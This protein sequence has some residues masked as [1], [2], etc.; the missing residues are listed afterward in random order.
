MEPDA[1][2]AEAFGAVARRLRHVTR[3]ALT[4]LGVT[5]WQARALWVLAD[6]GELRPGALAERL[7]I[8]PRS[9]TE[10]VD[11]LQSRGLAERRPDPADR[12]ATL[13]ALTAEGA[14]LAERIGAARGAEADRF[15]G[16]LDPDERAE[17][18][19][20]LRRLSG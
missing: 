3:E 4:P 5:P 12:R 9:A 18:A 14:R 10:V 13:V 20:M 15:F 7:R 8:A 16:A 2:L 1:G 6:A 19:R 17:L 11:D